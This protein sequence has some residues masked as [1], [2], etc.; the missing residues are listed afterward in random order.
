MIV[1]MMVMMV[2]MVMMAMKEKC[3]PQLQKWIATD[4]P[5]TR[6]QRL[7]MGTGT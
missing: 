1:T 4:R 7:R 6:K 5:I 2:M 3:V